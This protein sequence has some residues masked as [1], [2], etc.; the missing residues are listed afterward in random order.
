MGVNDASES[1]CAAIHASANFIVTDA[2][3]PTPLMYCAVVVSGEE[4]KLPVYVITALHVVAD[5]LPC[6]LG[7]S[8]M[9]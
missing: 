9:Y 6:F 8:L 5:S 3:G 2:R 7:T 1:F 4:I